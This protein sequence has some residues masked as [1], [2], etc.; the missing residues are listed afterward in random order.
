MSPEISVDIDFLWLLEVLALVRQTLHE[1]YLERLL[2][3]LKI[4]TLRQPRSEIE[5][6]ILETL[7]V[8]RSA[9]WT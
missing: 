8:P 1:S 2:P 5:M 3:R 9:V 4:G 6:V 7:G